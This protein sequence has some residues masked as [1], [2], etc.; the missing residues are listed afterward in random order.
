MPD[1]DVVFDGDAL[2]LTELAESS[3]P[4]PGDDPGPLR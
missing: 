1:G 2:T 3:M 4:P